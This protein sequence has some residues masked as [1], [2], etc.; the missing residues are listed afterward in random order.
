MKLKT[1]PRQFVELTIQIL[2][3]YFFFSFEKIKRCQNV[4][5][6]NDLSIKIIKASS[7]KTAV[8]YLIDLSANS[9]GDADEIKL[10]S[11][12]VWG[13]VRKQGRQKKPRTQ[14]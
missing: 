8:S 5:T 3:L 10:C 14:Q 12:F 13:L 2:F 6:S 9:F 11:N 7:S 1:K 4:K